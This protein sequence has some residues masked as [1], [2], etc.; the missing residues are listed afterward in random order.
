MD[1]NLNENFKFVN[2]LNRKDPPAKINLEVGNCSLH[3]MRTYSDNRG[4]L[5]V[6]EFPEE[7]PFIAKRY[8]L[9][10]EV[11]ENIMRGEHAH[12]LCKQFLVCLKGSCKVYLDDGM[13]NLSLT[14]SSPNVGIYIPEMIWGCQYEYSDDSIL[15][16]FASELYDREEY[17]RDYTQ[18]K[19]MLKTEFT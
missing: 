2:Y 10:Y 6:G 18:F 3:L 15:L 9:I 11:P 19:E 12:K 17:I 1:S 7:L 4:K 5:S 16:V 14:L 8:F 13:N